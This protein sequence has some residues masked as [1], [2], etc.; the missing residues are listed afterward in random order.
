ML[1]RAR[2]FEG[3]SDLET[4]LRVQKGDFPAPES[5]APDL[6][7]EVAAVVG[8]AMRREPDERYQSAD[9]M[10]SDVERVMR[11]AFRPVGQTELKRWLSEFF[12]RKHV[13]P[14]S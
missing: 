13:P 9:E 14:I 10:L 8:R 6:P 3:P 1:T 12:V 4:L 11:T 5:V 7:P 2:P